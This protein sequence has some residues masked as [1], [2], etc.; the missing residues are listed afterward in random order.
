MKRVS[1]LIWAVLIVGLLAFTG[2]KPK[3]ADIEK[4]LTTALGAYPGVQ[5]SV[6]DGVAT[7]SGQVADEATRSAAEEAAKGV[8]NVKSVNNL[9]TVN[10]PPA[11]VEINPDTTLQETANAAI[12]SLN[13]PKVQA[14][15]QDGVITL[16]GE[17]KKADL[18]G[19]MTK[20]N[21]LKPKSIDNKLTI[22]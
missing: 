19:L 5:A 21:E 9:L 1:S 18:R 4:S 22:K 12:S 16:T 20:L 2:C 7:L 6:K 15:V 17:I 8:K 14:S 11:P 10:P 3:D 13:L